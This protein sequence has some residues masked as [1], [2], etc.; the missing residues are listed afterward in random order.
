MTDG[1]GS[2]MGP[3]VGGAGWGW[4]GGGGG[5]GPSLFEET[6]AAV[7]AFSFEQE[8]MGAN[9]TPQ[10]VGKQ[11]AKGFLIPWT[12]KFGGD[13]YV[14]C[15]SG[16]TFAFEA[17]AEDKFRNPTVCV[18]RWHPCVT[19]ASAFTCQALHPVLRFRTD[20]MLFASHICVADTDSFSKAEEGWE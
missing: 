2:K 20:N 1:Y 17:V 6:K 16:W 18:Q 10:P 9:R 11:L 15:S 8:K 13:S 7:L 12:S 14:I 19:I 5:G 3:E 4:G